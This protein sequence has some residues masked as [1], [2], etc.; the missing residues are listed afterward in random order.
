[1]NSIMS[2]GNF[3]LYVTDKTLLTQVTQL[4]L[5]GIKK[6]NID[7]D[8]DTFEIIFII[9]WEIIKMLNFGQKIYRNC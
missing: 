8:T 2:L 3:Y 1:M 7:T 5:E 4:C 9:N 6:K